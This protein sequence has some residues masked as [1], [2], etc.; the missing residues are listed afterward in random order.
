VGAG[1]TPTKPGGEVGGE[2]KISLA[3]LP[4][5]GAIRWGSGAQRVTIFTDFRCGY[6]RALVSALE[7]MNVQV[8]ERPISVLGPR[9]ISNRVY[10]AKDR[11][12]AL[13]LAYAG[14]APPAAT[15]DTSGLDANEGFARSHGFSGTPVIVRAD[16]AVIHGY[17]PKEFLASWLKGAKS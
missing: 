3:A 4:A 8:D 5:A 9:E 7:T 10:C 15:C 17:R 2:Q 13:R 14:E 1:Y 16:G 12:K 11:P 6:C